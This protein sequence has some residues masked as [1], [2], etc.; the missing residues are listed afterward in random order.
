MGFFGI[1]KDKRGVQTRETVVKLPQVLSFGE[2][3]LTIVNNEISHLL[4]VC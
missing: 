4:S 2:R 3:S 1:G